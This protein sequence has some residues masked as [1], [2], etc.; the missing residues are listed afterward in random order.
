MMLL[1]PEEI[2]YIVES[3]PHG[4]RLVETHDMVIAKA[5]LKQVVEWGDEPCP[6]SKVPC[7]DGVPYGDRK[8]GCSECWQA[9]K[10]E[11]E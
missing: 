5:Q 6:H 9:L 10:K 11:V 1:S 7:S 4:D 8:H 3:S 2:Q